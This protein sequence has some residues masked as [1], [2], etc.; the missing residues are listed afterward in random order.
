MFKTK[1]SSWRV[2]LALFLTLAL[3]FAAVACAPAADKKEA[4]TTA[5]EEVET[6]TAEAEQAEAETTAAE[7]ASE[8]SAEADAEAS[9]TD[10]DAD[11][12]SAAKTVYPLT[13]KDTSDREVSF[14]A[15]PQKIVSL[16]P[17]MTETVYALGVEDRLIGNTTYCDYPEAAKKITKVGTLREPDFEKITELD[18]D[19]ILASTHVSDETLAKFEEL[20]IPTLMLYDEEHYTGLEGILRT[21][22]E[23]LDVQDAAAKVWQDVSSRIDAVKAKNKDVAPIP[24]YYVVGFGESGDYTAGGNTFLGELLEAAGGQNVAKDVT[25][26]SFSAE[27]LLEADPEIIL[28]PGWAKESFG[29]SEPYSKLSAVKNGKVFAVDENTFS[30]Q[31]PRMADAVEALDAILH[32]AK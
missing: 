11:S 15:A 14:A 8:P 26:W 21:L 7:N 24:V 30:R 27:K 10:A 18:P 19:L 3:T 28:V 31:G 20:K 9:Q 16:G 29:S 17:N 23:V 22:G 25:D 32:P 5:A 13:V 12:A 1:H 2:L 6:T 4:A